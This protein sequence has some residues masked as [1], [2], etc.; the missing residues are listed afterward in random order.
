MK[1][2]G[3]VTC[4]DSVDNYGGVLQSFALQYY[5]RKNGYDAFLIKFKGDKSN[6]SKLKS[7][8]KAFVFRRNN[9]YALRQKHIKKRNFRSFKKKYVNYFPKVFCGEL[10]IK[11]NPPLADF[12]ITGSDQVWNVSM[13]SDLASIYFLNFG[14]KKSKRI[15]YAAS[16]G[17]DAFPCLDAKIFCER[18]D[19]FDKISIRESCGVEICKNFGFESD[20]CVDSTLLLPDL[21]YKSIMSLPKYQDKYFFF[22]PVNVSDS[23]E[24]YWNQMVT[25][26]HSEN[27]L[28][29]VTTASGYILE[30]E[31]FNGAIYDYATVEEWLSNIYYANTIITTSFHGL[32]FSLIFKK[33][34]VYFP[35]KGDLAKGNCRMEDLLSSVNLLKRRAFS[36]S[37]AIQLIEEGI[38]YDNVDNKKLM[39]LIDFSKS[40][41]EL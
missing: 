7:L 28:P 26:C 23:E 14:P 4:W 29:V 39:E 16:F 18:L 2:V 25:Y 6:L 31:L 36:F 24:I 5:L 15:S 12:Y 1:K 10:D 20:L 38:D 11:K 34:F 30:S 22:Y 8:I 32:V 37:N 17:S 3:I 13:Y 35:L 21:S 9:G 40:F 19:E 27:I 33:N 41:L